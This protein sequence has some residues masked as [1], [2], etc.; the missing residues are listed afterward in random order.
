MNTTFPKIDNQPLSEK[1]RNVLLKMMKNGAFGASGRLPSEDKLAEN[2]G[3]SR[4]V[5][6]DVLAFFE[7]KGFIFRRRGIG[8]LINYHV[9]KLR[10]RFDLEPEFMELI[11]DG[12]YIPRVAF[13]NIHHRKAD[14]EISDKLALRTGEKIYAIE[15]LILA[16]QLPAIY[17]IDYF[18]KKIIIEKDYSEEELKE[19]IFNFLSQRCYRLIVHDVTTIDPICADKKLAEILDI[20]SGAPVLHLDKVGYD[21]D[22]KPVLC[23]H[24]YRRPGILNYT[25]LRSTL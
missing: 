21:I 24:D 15:R 2:L 1:V 11:S 7:Q 4:T 14:S 19:P 5:I 20:K 16:D 10:N 3:V 23:S 8:T 13:V 9:L 6:R 12:G 17:C 18:S 25:L 22:Q